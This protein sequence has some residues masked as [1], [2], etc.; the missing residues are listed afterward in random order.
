MQEGEVKYSLLREQHQGDEVSSINQMTCLLVNNVS[1]V[2]CVFTGGM[3][4]SCR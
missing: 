2:K 3:L 1:S 4:T